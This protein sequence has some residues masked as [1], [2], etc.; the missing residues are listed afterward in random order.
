MFV[1]Y[2][3]ILDTDRYAN[4]YIAET[5]KKEA[6]VCENMENEIITFFSSY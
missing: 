4:L 3:I 1:D 2:A 5:A 6:K